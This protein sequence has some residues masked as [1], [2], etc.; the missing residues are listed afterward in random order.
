MEDHGDQKIIANTTP[1]FS[2]GVNLNGEYKGFDITI[3]LQGVAKRD[4]VFSNTNSWDGTYFWGIT[5]DTYTSM[6]TTEHY[7]RWTEENRNGY[8][9]KYYLNDEVRKTRSCK[10]NMYK[11]RHIYVSRISSWDIHSRWIGLGKLVAKSCVCL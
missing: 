11:M 5:G 9:P 6:L 3:F 8:F 2:F 4:A 1:R 7:D 10:V